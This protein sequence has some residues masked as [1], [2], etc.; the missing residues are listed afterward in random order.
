MIGFPGRAALH[1]R[2]EASTA[3]NVVARLGEPESPARIRQ[4]RAGLD[5][6]QRVRD[7]LLTELVNASS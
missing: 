7:L 5:M 3:Q 2:R 1:F 4:R 6:P